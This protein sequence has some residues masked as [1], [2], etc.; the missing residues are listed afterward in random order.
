MT[1][2]TRQP[3]TAATQ[4]PA[5][6]PGPKPRRTASRITWLII[7]AIVVASV[8]SVDISWSALGQ[9]PSQLV[10]YLGLMFGPPDVSALGEAVRA[11][12]LSIQMAWFG[13]VLGIIVSFPLS[14][15]AAR[16]IAP[17]YV[18]W[19]LRGLFALIRAVPEVVIAVLILSITGLTAFTGA[20]ALAVG[21][22]G[23]LGKWGYESFESIAAGPVEA[24][25]A[26]GASRLQIMR[27]GVWPQ[28][29]PEVFAFWLY[30]F[31]INVRESAILGLIG[32]GGIGK[33]L[34]DNVQYRIWDAVGMLLIVVIVITMIIDQI[35]GMI[36]HRIIYGTWDLPLLARF[37]GR[38]G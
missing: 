19:P 10:K 29:Q 26:T 18:R 34:M 11:T 21:S 33:M 12:I 36:R 37:R 27:W 5:T 30:R 3:P 14:F 31:E 7:T 8:W 35:S 13:S 20:L 17:A 4:T 2:T 24:A 6:G 25:S 28:S 1:T 15:L 22:I 9:F 38:R 16:G 32:A 23:T